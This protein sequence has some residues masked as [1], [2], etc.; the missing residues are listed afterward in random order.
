MS[1]TNKGYDLSSSMVKARLS[2]VVN[3]FVGGSEETSSSLVDNKNRTRFRRFGL[4]R[5]EF[6]KHPEVVET[7]FRKLKERLEGW[8]IS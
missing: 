3:N 4:K 7:G 5:C 8:Y 2:D 1:F 6:L